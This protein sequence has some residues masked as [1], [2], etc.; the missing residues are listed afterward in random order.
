MLLSTKLII[1]D[2]YIVKLN[3]THEYDD[4]RQMIAKTKKKMLQTLI[5]FFTPTRH[6]VYYCSRH[7]F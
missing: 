1:D 7:Y 4:S 5:F 3:I 6:A 2:F